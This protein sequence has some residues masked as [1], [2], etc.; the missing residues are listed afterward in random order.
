MRV[1]NATKYTVNFP[2][3]PTQK[4]TIQPNSVSGNILPNTQFLSMMVGVYTPEQIAFIVSGPFEINM[5]SSIPVTASYVVQSLDEAIARFSPKSQVEEMPKE[6]KK[7]VVEEKINVEPVI[8]EVPAEVD[9]V[10][11]VV[12]SEELFP[13]EIVAETDEPQV[14]KKSK[15]SSKKK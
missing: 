13:E 11:D 3:T 4:I 14:V 1:Y 5:C 7:V 2:L 12:T 6:E 9:V 10:E 15:K 8:T